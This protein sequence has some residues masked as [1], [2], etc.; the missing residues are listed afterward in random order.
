MMW[1]MPRRGL[2]ANRLPDLL[3]QGGVEVVSFGQ[4]H[5]QDDDLVGLIRGRPA[6]H[7][8]TGDFGQRIQCGIDFGAADA[9]TGRVEGGIA[10]PVNDRATIAR[11]LHVIAV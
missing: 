3:L 2:L 4:H 7:Y 6:Y 1:D 8:S 10:T 9:H 11:E 5:T